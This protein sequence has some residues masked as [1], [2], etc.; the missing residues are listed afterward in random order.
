M[1]FFASQVHGLLSQDWAPAQGGSQVPPLAPRAL[2]TL[3]FPAAFLPG[4]DLISST[5]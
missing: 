4:M 5:S 1:V 3:P 2:C